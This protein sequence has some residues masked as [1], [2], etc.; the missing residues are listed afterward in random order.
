[1]SSEIMAAYWQAPPMARTLA[2]AILVTSIMAY[3]GPLPISWIYF[4]ESRL[5]KLPPEIWRLVT[6]FLLSSPQLGIVLDP[7]FAYL[8]LGQLETSNPKFQRKEDVLW[9]LITVGGFIIIVNRIFLGGYFF[10]QGLIIA[11]CYTA[12][13][14]ARGAKSNFF[15]FTVPAQLIPYCM[16][17]SS[18][19]M[20]PAV[21]PLQITGILAAHWHDFMTRLWPE[22][23]GGSSLLPTP[24][25]LSRFVET[26]RVFRREYGT[27]IRPGSGA[28]STGRTTGASTGS[29]L[30]D[31]WRTRGSGHRLGGD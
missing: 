11:L 17:L 3:F 21:I 23:G 16:L 26:P 25:F 8:Y 9:Y 30:P 6:S 22:F 18:L 1:M 12:V 14:D 28:P 10:L 24:A 15:F 7:Y 2:T 5:F 4:D 31:S 19:L 13:Q 27:A 20:N 29:V